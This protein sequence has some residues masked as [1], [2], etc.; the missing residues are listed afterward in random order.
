Y[1]CI[2]ADRGDGMDENDAVE[3]AVTHLAARGFSDICSSELEHQ[4]F[5]T[6]KNEIVAEVTRHIRLDNVSEMKFRPVHY[7]LTPKN[8][9]VFDYRRAA[10]VSPMCLAKYT[11]LVLLAAPTIEAHR[12]PE[13]EKRVFSARFK[14]SG[15][16]VFASD[17]NYAA[18]RERTKELASNPECKFIV[19]CDIASFYDRINI[20][21]VESTLLSIG[22][23]KK[24]AGKI[25]NLLL[26]STKKDS[27]GIPVGNVAS[28]IVAEASL[29]D[30]D[31][32]L[33]SEKVEFTRYVDDF[34]LFAPDIVTA[35]IWLSKLNTRLSRD[36]LVLN[37]AKTKLLA[38]RNAEDVDSH[39]DKREH[40]D[41]EK[42]L[43]SVNKL[44]GGY[45]R[46]VRTFILP[47]SDKHAAFQK[48]DINLEL[49]A[50][51]DFKIVEFDSVQKMV[52]ATLVQKKFEV[53]PILAD[54]CRKHM[55]ALD[56][57]VDMLIR[58]GDL[59]PDDVRTQI[60]EFFASVIREKGFGTFEWH[61]AT[62][63]RLFSNEKYFCKTSLFNIVKLITKETTTYP[64]VIALKGLVG[65]LS[66]S[67]FRTLRD[68][69][70]RAD[71]WERRLMLEASV[72]LPEEE[73]KA[74][75]K[76]IK[77]GCV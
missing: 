9:Y 64:A 55:Y 18:W 34:R 5:S 56:Y 7:L 25:N 77:A 38:V 15:V 30:I 52:V 6:F 3:L 23:D 50:L 29:I 33:C 65:K 46:I 53:L 10:I 17:V 36:G 39:L 74:W 40:D 2:S 60:R 14:P 42:V 48:I 26:F 44:T 45:N 66:R 41:A 1:G 19:H 63:S 62:L 69:F 43:R 24:L 58:N 57:F 75:L 54:T 76:S 67:E 13:S 37:T 73:R 21:R 11:A 47:A 72:V 20:H 4:L 31:N 68:W 28:R 16:E 61:E 22:V 12:I 59:I 70:D 35:Q 32:Y 8:R 71:E 51:E 27:Y 49:K